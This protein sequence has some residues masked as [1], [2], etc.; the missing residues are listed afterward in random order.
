[1]IKTRS[2]LEN[3]LNNRYYLLVTTTDN[4]LIKCYAKMFSY[5]PEKYHKLNYSIKRINNIPKIKMI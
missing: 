4:K 1:M 3:T 5:A 2:K